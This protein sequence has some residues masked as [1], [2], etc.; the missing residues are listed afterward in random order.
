MKV[1]TSY[2]LAIIVCKGNPSFIA[3]VLNVV[4][5]L[6]KLYESVKLIC[7]DISKESE[8]F[9]LGECKNLSIENLRLQ[10][11]GTSKILSVYYFRKKVFQLV[12]ST[13]HDLLWIATGDTAV[14][15]G[16]KLK[17]HR[18]VMCLLELYDAVPVYNFL[19]K[20]LSQYAHKI[21]TAEYNR[22]AILRVRWK[23]K[24][25]PYVL[26]NK[27]YF[28]PLEQASINGSNGPLV[29]QVKDEIGKGKK[30]ILYQGIITHY[31][32]LDTIA[33][34]TLENDSQFV[35][36]IVGKDFDYID[37]LKEINPNIIHIPFIDAPLHLEITKLADIGIVVY[38][39]IDLNNIYCAPNKIWEYAMFSKPMLCN[40]IPG[41]KYTVEHYKAGLCTDFNCV[42]SVKDT[43]GKIFSDYKEYAA[44]AATFYDSVDLDSIIKNIVR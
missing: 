14:S 32:R 30:I 27:P 12:N 6:S 1:E 9:L 36:L 44:N 13:P 33:K 26:P 25:T 21:V 34:A 40:D 39:F 20:R 35:F 8:T 11:R 24:H 2:K 28:K 37:T 19:L 16:T 23:L 7:G 42:E 43:M 10:S 31:R 4:L 18:F 15:L 41:L 17:E 5:G 38:D 29:Q 22:S 3:P